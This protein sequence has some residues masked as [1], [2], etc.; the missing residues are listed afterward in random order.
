MK[1]NLIKTFL[2][3]LSVMSFTATFAQSTQTQNELSFPVSLAKI[4]DDKLSKGVQVI[5]GT[6]GLTIYKL[7]PPEAHQG[8]TLMFDDLTITIP[9]HYHE[10][11]TQILM[12][13]EGQLILNMDG[14]EILLSAG[15]FKIIPAYVVHSLTPVDG[16]CRIIELDLN[17]KNFPED[18]FFLE[19]SPQLPDGS[20]RQRDI[21]G[22]ISD[23]TVSEISD[24]ISLPQID[25][26]YFLRHFNKG[27]F[28]AYEIVPPG[29]VE[30][31]K[32]S[33]AL[34]EI[35]EAPKHFH[36]K[37]TETFVVVN[38]ILEAEIEG[39]EYR[40]VPGNVVKIPPTKNHHFK[41]ALN[42]PARVICI[43]SPAFDPTDFYPCD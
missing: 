22:V 37:G 9:H 23:Q 5:Q 35:N 42:H 12:V 32:W 10:T 6:N 34:I 4:Q 30:G 17:G 43:N 14:S 11:Q 28:A 39:V 31:N 15:D 25:P 13:L 38:G 8:W 24:L 33:I 2:V 19:K 21:D 18:V 36:L 26:T 16:K 27:S 20:E 3:T 1:I 7:I 29:I 41:S 40:F